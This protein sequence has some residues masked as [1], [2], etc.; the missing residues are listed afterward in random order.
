MKRNGS[1]IQKAAYI[2]ALVVFIALLV[3]TFQ[4][5]GHVGEEYVPGVYGTAFALLP[6]AVA[7]VLALISREVY[8]SLFMGILVGA[9]LYSSGN[10]ELAFNTM[11][12]KEGS[13]MLYQLTDISHASILVFVVLLNMLTT[14]MNKSGGSEAFGR[15]ASKH[16]KSKVGAQL[17][18]MLLGIMIFVDD[19]FNC[20]TVGSVMR[21]LTD[22]YKVS[23]SKL[24]YIID[25]TAA[26]ICI[27]APISSWAAGVSYSL[28]ADV[29]VNGFLV[30]VRT[31]PYNFYALGTIAMM[32]YIITKKFDYGPMKIHEKNAE[33]G[34]LHNLGGRQPREES[35]SLNPGTGKISSLIVPVV[36]LIVSCIIGML[37]TGGFFEG[38]GFVDAFAN[39][40]AAR[41]FVLGN[42]ITI[43]ITFFFYMIRKTLPFKDFMSSLPE[44]WAAMVGPMSIL[45]MAW[46]L[47]GMTG[48]LGA[49]DFIH[50]LF[51]SSAGS[52]KMFLPFA[53]FL[54]ALLLAFSTGTSWGTFSIL[55]PIVCNVFDPA[56]EMF[57][58][59]IAAC[60]AGSVCGDHCSPISDT[61]IMSS[62][63]AKSDHINHVTTQMPYALTVA[64]VAAVSYLLAGIVGQVLNG[65]AAMVTLPA[66]IALMVL[67][68]SVMRRKMQ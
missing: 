61:T 49:R 55:I 19:G 27:I 31:I 26:P 40:D 21:P 24:A 34:D 18:T 43:L 25:A 56:Q 20:M 62:A 5:P 8:S 28:P 53:I 22:K 13:G 9:L 45:V 59:S 33:N 37:Y 68:L 58:I 7:I 12:Y 15:W 35:V 3:R 67:T 52:V 36:L 66:A 42:L 6:P 29:D 14:L 30:F 23:R 39:S 44:G 48:L 51:A 2:A 50:D 60:L 16:I 46:T 57:I 1:M 41:G 32:L 38:A 47:S 54:V 11:M 10:L 65:P 64:A 17:A 63:G 4:V